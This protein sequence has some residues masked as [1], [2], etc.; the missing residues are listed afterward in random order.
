M[1]STRLNNLQREVLDAFFRRED[2][3]FLTGGAALAGYYLKHRETKDLDLFTTENRME[4]GV[5]ALTAAAQEVGAS[6]EPLR[7]SPDFRRFL[8][9]HDSGAVV[10]DLVRDLAPQIFS[11]KSLFGTIRVDPPEEILANKLCTLLSRAEIRDLVDVWALEKRGY[12][13]ETALEQASLKDA[14][15]TAGQLAWVLSEIK[16][17]D[18]AAPPGG[19]SAQELREYLHDLR[20]RL[21]GQAFPK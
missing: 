2:R 7:T 10:V 1:S 20:D 3:F 18:D 8:L 17:G 12:S 15:M 6:I 21:A 13:I 16:I 11:E 14:G 4:E 9:R 5:S 19:L